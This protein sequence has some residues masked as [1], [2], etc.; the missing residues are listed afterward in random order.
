MK[1][2]EKIKKGKARLSSYCKI[3]CKDRFACVFSL[4]DLA[5]MGSFVVVAWV[6]P[7]VTLFST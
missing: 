5:C 3:H 7:G 2:E 6:L 1:E 4:L